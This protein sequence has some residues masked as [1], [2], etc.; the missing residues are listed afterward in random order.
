MADL[1][2]TLANARAL[3][4]AAQGLLRAPRRKAR[5]EDVL[6]AI[7]HMGA[8]QIDTISVVARSPYLVLWSRLGQYEPQWLEQLHAEGRLFEYW[9]HEACFLPIEDFALYR[10]RMLDPLSQ[11]WK[12]HAAAMQ[13]ELVAR[14]MAAVREQGPVRA[15]DFEQKRPG[16]GWW[17]WKG[18]KRVLENL[19]TAGELMVPRRQGFQRVYDLRE[20][21]LPAWDDG[22]LPAHTDVE[23]TLVLNAVR[24]LGIV[25]AGQ[26]ADY[27]RMRK[28]S[29]PTIVQ[30]LATEQRLLRVRVAGFEHEYFVHPDHA[31]TLDQAAAG[32]LKP[33]LTTLLSPF[34]PVVWD[35][36]RAREM[37][38][39]DYRIECYTPAPKRIYGYYALPI[40]RRGA[41]VG[42][43][44]AKAHRREGR[45]EVKALY[46]E[47][48]VKS[49][50]ALAR[51]VASAI[52]NC[53]AWHGTPDVQIGKTQPAALA[54]PLRQAIRQQLHPA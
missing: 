7:R 31:E 9:S 22:Q 51:D 45:F 35:R 13:P 50:D 26:V 53:A 12:Y 28:R 11:G 47:P 24:A 10:H 49:N 19:L 42:R 18:E 4:L 5:K 34:D 21:V 33:A 46:L 20:R 23:R 41:L 43:L 44:D 30:Q 27:F 32:K 48:G 6:A 14:V 39:F 54:K 38:D 8:L 16:G 3:H 29:T 1:R 37:F 25:R 40:L 17:Q 15:I 2:L 52:A 36:A